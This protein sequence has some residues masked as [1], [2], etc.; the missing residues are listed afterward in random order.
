M[1]VLS[2]ENEIC[3]ADFHKLIGALVSVRADNS[4]A[5]TLF[6]ERTHTP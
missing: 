5:L 6:T 4:R 1:A 2:V 3:D